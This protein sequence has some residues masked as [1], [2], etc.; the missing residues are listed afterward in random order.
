MRFSDT[1]FLALTVQAVSVPAK[2]A[3]PAGHVVQDVA[4]AREY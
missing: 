2:H 3:D 1:C 4:P